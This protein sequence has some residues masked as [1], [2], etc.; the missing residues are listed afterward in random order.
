M[1]TGYNLHITHVHIYVLI[2]PMRNGNMYRLDLK[3]SQYLQV[4]ILPMRNGNPPNS[5]FLFLLFSGSYPTYEEWKHKPS[6]LRLIRN[7][8]RSY[9]TY[10]EWKHSKNIKYLP[11]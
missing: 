11:D 10:E 4:L 8:E 2:L 5:Y 6:N 1:E 9:P 3:I 7:S